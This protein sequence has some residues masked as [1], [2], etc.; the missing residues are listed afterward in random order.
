MQSHNNDGGGVTIA[1]RDGDDLDAVP[2]THRGLVTE[3]IRN[4]FRNPR[5]YFHTIAERTIVPNLARYLKK[6]VESGRWQLILADT[7]MMR[8]ETV[9]G[10]RWSHPDQ[11]S[12]LLVPTARLPPH[13]ELGVL[14]SDLEFVHWERIAFAGGLFAPPRLTTLRDYG[15]QSTSPLFPLESTTVFGNTSC[16][17]VLVYNSQGQAGLISHENGACHKLG[18]V[19]DALGWVFAELAANRMP[20]FGDSPR[21]DFT[22]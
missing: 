11:H 19:R 7:Y 5:N 21:P 9:A 1:L 4:A 8:R 13:P 12:S 15:L 14:Y 17:D 20:E 6:F 16:G 22:P 18:S 3:T 10:F 2:Q